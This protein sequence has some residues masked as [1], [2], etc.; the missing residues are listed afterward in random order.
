MLY[1]SNTHHSII[2]RVYLEGIGTAGHED[3]TTSKEG[4]TEREQ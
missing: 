2:S 1:D 3:V 4:T